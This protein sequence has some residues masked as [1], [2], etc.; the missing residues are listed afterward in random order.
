MILQSLIRRLFPGSQQ[1]AAWQ[2]LRRRKFSYGAAM[3]E[4]LEPR[5]LMSANVITVQNFGSY[6]Y[7]TDFATPSSAAQ[8]DSF[9]VTY[10]G[11][12]ATFVGQNGTKFQV[13]GQLTDTVSMNSTT[14]L[15]LWMYLN[16]PAS[17]VKITGDG[18]A[19]LAS[20]DVNFGYLS[21]TNTLT[22]SDV[23]VDS[24]TVFGATG[25]DTVRIE[26][27]IVNQS[28]MTNLGNSNADTLILFNS[29]V[30]G[31]VTGS[32]DQ[33][34]FDHS[35][36]DGMTFLTQL[37]S[38]ATLNSTASTFKGFFLD[39]FGSDATINMYGSVHG[40]NTFNS[41][42]ILIG[43]PGHEATLN[44]DQTPSAP[45]IGVV[46]NGPAPLLIGVQYNPS[47]PVLTWNNQALLAIMVDKTPPP[48]ATRALAIM[49]A[50]IYDV[51][52]AI[53]GTPGLYVS[54]TASKNTS[55]QA[56]VDAAADRV[57]ST[58][59]P[60][61]KATFDAVLARQLGQIIDV[62]AKNNGVNLGNAIADA[63]ILRRQN[64][65]S[66]QTVT[67]NGPTTPGSWQPTLPPTPLP[68][69][70]SGAT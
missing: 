11:T 10:S 64:D 23:I 20:V 56:A 46:N 49:H 39:L 53:N 2:R 17:T 65:G 18:V 30:H 27:S 4:I 59:Y 34:T 22:M 19:K 32:A 25:N 62:T 55:M 38:S 66:S 1:P 47:E 51:V 16:S 28:L 67:F 69:Y 8:G 36:V 9:K 26:N 7:L 5:K 50:A 60:A 40:P 37:G 35:S 21:S 57:L 15:H 29:A 44:V 24:T 54:L 48:K 14:P 12:G 70:H 33:V 45:S 63:M 13:G 52:N 43:V 6:A 31:G 3:I 68:C 42:E 61:Q 58:L 41:N